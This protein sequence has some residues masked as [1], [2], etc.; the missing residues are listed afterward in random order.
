FPFTQIL[1]L[2]DK[3]YGVSGD[4]LYLLEGDTDNGKAIPWQVRTGVTDFDSKQ[5]KRVNSVYIGGQVEEQISVTLLAGP[6]GQHRYDYVTERQQ[7]AQ[8]TLV[9]FGKGIASQRYYAA[10]F[11]DANGKFIAIDALDFDVDTLKR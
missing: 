3:Y 2:H 7:D 10:E 5:L 4:G 11:G 8:N 9:K 6:A 1:R